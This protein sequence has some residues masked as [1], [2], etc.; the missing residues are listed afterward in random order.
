MRNVPEKNQLEIRIANADGSADH[1]L[2]AVPALGAFIS[3]CAWSP[4]GKTILAP[5]L[6]PDFRWVTWA[7]NVAD[8]SV[9]EFSSGDE[10][11]GR[12]AWL[13][14]GKAVVQ[15]I[16]TRPLDL[17]QLF[18]I[19]VDGKTRQRFTNDLTDYTK[20]L[21]ITTDGKMLTTIA[22]TR[23]SHIFVVPG[24]K[25]ELAKQ[26]TFGE[27][28]DGDIAAGPNGKLLVQSNAADISLMNE[29]G[30]GR[31]APIANVRD[32][33]TPSHCGD[34]YLL[35][36]TAGERKNQLI[37]TDPDG[38]NPV[39]IAENVLFATCSP[40]G[41]WAIYGAD[42]GHN[43]VRLPIEGGTPKV[44]ATAPLGITGAISRDGK[45]VLVESQ[46]MGPDSNPIQKIS[47]IPAE[48]GAAVHVFPA[49]VGVSRAWWSPDGKAIQFVLTKK[50]AGNIW[51][52]PLAGGDLRQVTN[53]TS[54]QI[55][56]F[57]W[58]DDGKDLLLARGAAHSDVVLISNFR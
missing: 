7:I 21:D 53:F 4:D 19:S 12:P 40:D 11:M 54:G 28:P 9:R 5:V 26:I 39:T 41:R 23:E 29:D 49:P 35:L 27:T 22:R 33:A 37:R 15:T 24:G 51:E 34:R 1:V 31:T 17:G 45:W 30:S 38:S 52:Q 14:D 32:Y 16:Q 25:T 55:F 18:V 10:G 20:V 50:G 2:R 6:G 46:E 44:I 3:G 43:L 47:V 13:P 36:E 58:T 42:S 48:G 8:G 57:N 56:G